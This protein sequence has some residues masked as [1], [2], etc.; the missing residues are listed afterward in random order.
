MGLEYGHES[1][2]HS[3]QKAG[4]TTM[5]S[6]PPSRVH[7]RAGFRRTF[8]LLL[9]IS[10]RSH[11]KALVFLVSDGVH[12]CI[13]YSSFGSTVTLRASEN[14]C[15]GALRG[16]LVVARGAQRE[17]VVPVE[18]VVVVHVRL[19]EPACAVPVVGRPGRL[20]DRARDPRRQGEGNATRAEAT[21]A[22]HA[23]S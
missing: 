14:V 3:K 4:V 12:T 2:D 20:D 16:H 11:G 1:I 9:P 21:Q 13:L 23:R 19:T 6:H 7:R 5:T 10:G 15:E 22:T 18:V 8:G 17:P